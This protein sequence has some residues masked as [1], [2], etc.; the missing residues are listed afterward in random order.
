MPVA[1]AGRT[2]SSRAAHE[3]TKKKSSRAGGEA[4]ASKS[5]QG[6]KRDYAP[7]AAKPWEGEP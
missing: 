4:A 2:S 7:I 6:R 5:V 3:L 1:Q